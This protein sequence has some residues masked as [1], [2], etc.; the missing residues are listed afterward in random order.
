MKYSRFLP[1]L[2][3]L[4]VAIL[5]ISGI[6]STKIINLWPFEFD[7]GTLLFPLSYIFWDI[8]TEVYGY[9]RSRIVIWTWF[10]AMAL[11]SWMILL[12]GILPSWSEW[13]FQ[14]DYHNI[15]MLTPRIFLGSILWYLTGEFAN[16]YIVAKMKVWTKW[17][18]LFARLIWSTV[19]GEALDTFLFVIIAF[20]GLM[21]SSLLIVIGISNYIFKLGTEI[22]L[23]PLTKQV[24]KRI[25]HH[26]QIDH[27]DDNT[28]FNPFKIF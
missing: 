8:L 9:K 18:Y 2:T 27:Y 21:S 22:I 16:S 20:W 13:T 15:L 5:L 1:I 24:I 19:V 3:W 7:G 14:S 12:V 28:N 25:K 17:K 11:M 10:I 4:F 26:E 6:V 23:F